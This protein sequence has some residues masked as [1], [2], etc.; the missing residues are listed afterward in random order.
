MRRVDEIDPENCRAAA[1]E[2][3]S[4]QRMTD[5]HLELYERLIRGAAAPSARA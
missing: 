3:F 1:R 4:L 2:R 5:Q